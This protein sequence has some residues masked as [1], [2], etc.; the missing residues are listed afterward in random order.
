MKQKRQVCCAVN[1]KGMQ[2]HD[3]REACSQGQGYT[4]VFGQEKTNKKCALLV[5]SFS[6]ILHYEQAAPWVFSS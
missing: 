5:S 1:E 2:A 4:A 6:F 3:Y